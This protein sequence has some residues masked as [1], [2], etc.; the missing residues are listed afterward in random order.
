MVFPHPKKKFLL[1]KIE[2]IKGR[3]VEQRTVKGYEEALG[4]GK[5]CGY[6]VAWGRRFLGLVKLVKLS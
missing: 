1:N 2:T 3:V 4:G 6:N 5:E